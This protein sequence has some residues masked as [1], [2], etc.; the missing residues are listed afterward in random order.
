MNALAYVEF[1]IEL[2]CTYPR[3]LGLTPH[4]LEGLYCHIDILIHY[5][6]SSSSTN[7][8]ISSFLPRIVVFKA[9][10]MAR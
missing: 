5:N 3:V 2:A 4:G 6:I 10:S 8:I 1:L 9:I 7:K